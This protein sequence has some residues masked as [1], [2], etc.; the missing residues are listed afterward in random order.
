MGVTFG[1]DGTAWG[2]GGLARR[3]VGNHQQQEEN[4]GGVRKSKYVQGLTIRQFPGLMNL[5]LAV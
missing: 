1:A 3:W 4:H 5:A 2:P